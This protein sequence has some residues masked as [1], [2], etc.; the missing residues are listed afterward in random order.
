M[1]SDPNV[2]RQTSTN[3]ISR[4]GSVFNFKRCQSFVS[5]PVFATFLLELNQ[6][7][8]REAFRLLRMKILQCKPHCPINKSGDLVQMVLMMLSQTP[9]EAQ[10][11][12][13]T[14]NDMFRASCPVNIDLCT[15]EINVFI[16]PTEVCKQTYL[17][18]REHVTE[19]TL[20]AH[21]GN[22][23]TVGQNFYLFIFSIFQYLSVI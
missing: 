9:S 10:H 20:Y 16:D 19:S 21:V 7:L 18:E 22:R 15:T 8:Y 12:V 17:F 13:G 11:P 6:W 23:Y 2:L 5:L 1:S 4:L 14:Q 3:C